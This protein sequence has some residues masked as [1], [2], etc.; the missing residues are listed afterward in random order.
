MAFSLIFQAVVTA[1]FGV[2]AMLVF[3]PVRKINYNIIEYIKIT[4][5]DTIRCMKLVLFYCCDPIWCG[6][7][8]RATVRSF[9][10]SRLVLTSFNVVLNSLGMNALFLDVNLLNYTWNTLIVI[11]IQCSPQSAISSSLQGKIALLP[12]VKFHCFQK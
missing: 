10:A 9:H 4:F 3:G 7:Q 12:K 1:L 2:L 6:L 8:F 11:L 5:P